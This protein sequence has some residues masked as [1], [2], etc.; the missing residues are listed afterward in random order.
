MTKQH[1][2]RA[3]IG[4]A[5]FV[6]IAMAAR[7][8]EGTALDGFS[9]TELLPQETVTEIADLQLRS[10]PAS[11][12][13]GDTEMEVATAVV[14]SL[15]DSKSYKDYLESVVAWKKSDRSDKESAA[16]I[17]IAS[18]EFKSSQ[19]TV[20]I[21]TMRNTSSGTSAF[22]TEVA[23]ALVEIGLASDYCQ[24]CQRSAERLLAGATDS[25]IRTHE[26]R[27]Y[28]AGL[29][30][31]SFADRSREEMKRWIARA[32]AACSKGSAVAAAQMGELFALNLVSAP[33]NEEYALRFWL[34]AESRGD[35]DSSVRVGKF[36]P[37]TEDNPSRR[38]FMLPRLGAAAAAHNSR[39]QFELAV[40]LL[41]T[42]EHTDEVS[43]LAFQLTQRAA[44]GGS[45]DGALLYSRLLDQR[46]YP[47]FLI[48]RWLA[49]A[50]ILGSEEAL[51]DL[52][53]QL[54]Q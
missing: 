53:A 16:R 34:L 30:A 36:L 22:D 7:G 15:N 45:S 37:R 5:V 24:E 18:P 47:R 48:D 28:S 21:E 52:S 20:L 50:V 26:V 25:A 38:E 9:C 39:G 4:P 42:Q 19:F 2:I 13:I 31:A 41:Q 33:N 1:L 27:M 10:M 29:S 49:E 17:L 43:D 8:A 32:D 51:E 44:Y 40:A 23:A 35:L 11:S 46:G 3:L 14:K 6:V 54:S 12:F